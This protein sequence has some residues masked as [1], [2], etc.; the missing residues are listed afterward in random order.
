MTASGKGRPLARSTGF[1]C[2]GP[3]DRPV[4]QG[5]WNRDLHRV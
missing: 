4:Y 2:P 3:G 1:N 5:C